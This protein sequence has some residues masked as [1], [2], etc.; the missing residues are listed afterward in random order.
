LIYPRIFIGPKGA[1]TPLHH[2]IW[3]THAWLAQLVGRKRWI[4]FPPDQRHLRYGYQVQPD[5]PDLEGFPRFQQATPLECTIG[6]G[7][8]IFVP[9]RWAHWVVSLDPTIS[10]THNYMG[11]GC[12]WS[13]MVHAVRERV[14][15]RFALRG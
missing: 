15:Q 1:V 14:L 2:D 7:D 13:A 10:L 12:F 4:M 9:S 3:D 6:P 11:R 8:V 5:Q